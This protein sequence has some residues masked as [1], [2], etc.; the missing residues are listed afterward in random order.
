MANL[1]G[2]S[3]NACMNCKGGNDK[4][5]SLAGYD[6]LNRTDGKLISDYKTLVD[7]IRK[8]VEQ[9]NLQV[10]E[11]LNRKTPKSR[12]RDGSERTYR[13]LIDTVFDI[14]IT[15]IE[16]TPD[17]N[18]ISFKWCDYSIESINCLI[19]QGVTDTLKALVKD[20]LQSNHNSK[21]VGEVELFINSVECERQAKHLDKNHATLLMDEAKPLT[22]LNPC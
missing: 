1:I 12:N 11:I 22:L 6:K 20:F 14:D 15:R 17:K 7:E 8:L 2:S 21:I 3:Q 10:D 9:N 19:R 13:K 16:R 18:E 5:S 4:I